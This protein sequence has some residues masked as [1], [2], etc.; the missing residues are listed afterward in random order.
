[1]WRD[2]VI[3][4]ALPAQPQPRG[5]SS[6]GR[7]NVPPNP[8]WPYPQSALSS[9]QLHPWPSHQGRRSRP[10]WSVSSNARERRDLRQ[11]ACLAQQTL[12]VH[13]PT[14]GEVQ[15]STTWLRKNSTTCGQA[16]RSSRSSALIRTISRDID[17]S[18]RESKAAKLLAESKMLK[19][20][21]AGQDWPDKGFSCGSSQSQIRTSSK[22]G[23]T[24]AVDDIRLGE[25][26]S[27]EYRR[28]IRYSLFFPRRIRILNI[29]R[30]LVILA[31]TI[32]AILRQYSSY[33][34]YIQSYRER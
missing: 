27:I 22:L 12:G 26:Y 2:H 34:P 23:P 21:M 28:R 16:R 33:P 17:G 3:G 1:M 5:Q 30:L 11:T 14:Q 8:Q 32:S 9:E 29:I 15:W 20:L 24:R 19:R 25:Y 7:N 13:R 4:Y 18:S 6:R 10:V 31:D